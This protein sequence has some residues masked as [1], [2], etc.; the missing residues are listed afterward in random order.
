MKGKD[1]VAKAHTIFDK[2]LNH[3]LAVAAN[4]DLSKQKSKDYDFIFIPL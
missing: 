2:V 1:P 3:V 4:R